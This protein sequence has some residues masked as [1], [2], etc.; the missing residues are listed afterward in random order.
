MF[1]AAPII[2]L[3][4]LPT[5]S[6]GDVVGAVSF[7]NDVMVVLSKA[8]CN[9]GTCHGNQSGKGGLKLSLRGQDPAADFAALTRDQSG[10]RVN[11]MDADRSLI[12]LKPTA[13]MP[14][15]G[16]RRFEPRSHEYQVLRRWISDGASIDPPNVPT[17][18]ALTASPAEAIVVDPQ[19]EL[20]LTVEAQYSDGRR[21]DVTSLAVYE[22][23]NQTLDVAPDGAVRRREFG[24]A[25]V[26]VRLLDRQTP[27][28][29]AFIPERPGFQWTSPTPAN[30]VDE[31]VFAKLKRLGINPSPVCDDATFLRRASLDLTGALP[32]VAAAREFMHDNRPDKRA[33]L[34]D[35]LLD[36]P[37]YAEF[38]ALKWADLLRIEEKTLDRKGVHNFHAWIRR[39]I[40]DGKPLDQFARELIAARGSTYTEPAA[41]YYRAMRDPATRGESTAQVFLGVRLQCAKCHN[42]PFDRWTQDNYYG[43]ANLFAR[44]DYKI[45]ENQRRDRNDSHEFDG[46]QVVYMRREGDFPDP[47]SG[48]PQPPRFLSTAAAGPAPDADRLVELANWIASPSNERFAQTQV[49][50]I[51]F[52]LMGRGIVDPIDDFRLTN[53]PSNPALLAALTADFVAS[54]FDLRH[55]IRTIAASTTY[56]L[57][58]TPNDTNTDDANFSHAAVRRLSAEQ[59]L[60]AISHVAGAPVEFNGYPLGVR[61]GQIPGVGAVRV[62]ERSRSAGDHFLIVF[63]KP[64]RLQ[65]CECERSDE[66]TLAQ[67]FQLV[68]GP[69]LNSLLARPDNRLAQL[70]ASGRPPSEMIDELFWT[71][72]GRGPTSDER[73]AAEQHAASAG[74]RRAAIEDLTWAIINSDEFLLRH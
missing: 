25:T 66:P 64:P 13:Q 43:W 74:D 16:G 14:H 50:R 33:R 38:W 53:P 32:S 17:L 8:G 65:A 59:L 39:S 71:A 31:H 48:S 55:M 4:L 60:D 68:S 44:V 9:L 7:R 20:R 21:R 27:V 69:L 73:S 56:Q 6:G 52:H 40:A 46:E 10:R 62:R 63:G 28:R 30:Y 3:G 35:H 70:A 24:E 5:P 19:H 47:R 41:N 29:V 2:V 37:E 22:T 12:L 23:S 1:C 34:V 67:T 49:N 58:S 36:R 45:I 61:A 11:R 51:W 15:G 42:H 57:A 26:V 72:L 54:G 18:V